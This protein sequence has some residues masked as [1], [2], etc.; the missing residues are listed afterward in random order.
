MQ[1]LVAPCPVKE[2][3]EN[4]GFI[5]IAAH[6]LRKNGDLRSLFTYKISL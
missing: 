4:T 6:I 3:G 5:S 1:F 2:K